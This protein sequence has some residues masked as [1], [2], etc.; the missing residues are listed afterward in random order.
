MPFDD[1]KIGDAHTF[2]LLAGDSFILKLGFP[3]RVN[4]K[5]P[6]GC[7]DATNT[8]IYG[9]A[10]YHQRLRVIV[11]K[12]TATLPAQITPASAT[13]LINSFYTPWY[14]LAP[15]EQKIYAIAHYYS[16]TTS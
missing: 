4:D 1:L 15:V 9:D 12:L 10:Y 2:D 8:T 16:T 6:G 5:I 3:I 13:L 7:K 14:Y 11:C